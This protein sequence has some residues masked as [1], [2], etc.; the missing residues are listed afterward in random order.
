MK[1]TL[2]LFAVLLVGTFAFAQKANVSKAKSKAMAEENPD[3]DGAKALIEAALND[4]TTK[5]QANTYWTA[6]L[7][8]EH[9][10]LAECRAGDGHEINAGMDAMRAV[11]L[12]KQA[13]TMDQQPDAK[14]KV[15][16]KF[17]KKITESMEKIYKTF[18]LVNYSVK[19][20]QNQDMKTAYEAMN[21]QLSILDLDYVKNDPKVQADTLLQKRGTYNQ[22]RYFA[23]VF[24]WSADLKDEAIEQLSGLIGTGYEAENVYEQICTI[25]LEKGDSASYLKYL[26]DGARAVP[27]SQWLTGNLINHYVEKGQYEEAKTYLTQAISNNPTAQLYNVLGSLNEELGELKEAMNNYTI[28]VGLDDNYADAHAN[29]GRFYYNRAIRLEDA[30]LKTNDPATLKDYKDQ[31]HQFLGQAIPEFEKA[32]ELD[33]QNSEFQRMLRITYYRYK[34]A[35]PSYKPKYPELLPQE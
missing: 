35:E 24:A 18:A 20:Q 25:Y 29:I 7:V 14:G 32:F 13:Y 28:A 26:Q 27:Q 5:D 30:S 8:Y 9:S 6:G 34:S 4:P 17:D 31:M 33:Q 15:K 12:Y 10:S 23:G 11:E 3:Y 19:M 2:I 1:R 16:P 21:T 22:L